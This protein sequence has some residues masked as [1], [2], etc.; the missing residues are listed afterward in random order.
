MSLFT[1]PQTLS[2]GT[3]DRIFNWLRQVP[4]KISGVY[5][6]TAA[7]ASAVSRLVTAHSVEKS[8][9]KRHQL[10]RVETCA[11]TNPGTDEPTDDVI[12]L[13]VTISHHPKHDPLD[14]EKQVNIVSAALGISG[15]TASFIA[16]EL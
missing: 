8:G 10:Q 3:T 13:N 14:V 11:L 1:S 16:E 7:L 12:I 15:F 6:E 2:D 5:Q 4:G 9:R